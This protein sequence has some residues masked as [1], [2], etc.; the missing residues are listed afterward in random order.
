MTTWSQGMNLNAVKHNSQSINDNLHRTESCKEK[1]CTHPSL[2]GARIAERRGT[3]SEDA[4][5][6]RAARLEE[7]DQQDE[8]PIHTPR[9]RGKVRRTRWRLWPPRF[10]TTKQRRRPI[11]V[12]LP[13]PS[14][15]EAPPPFRTR[16]VAEL[17]TFY[18]S[19]S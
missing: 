13:G 9:F 5:A 4:R 1:R 19:K 7:K 6:L 8:A 14:R 18:I 15:G 2:H 3:R 16:F 10:L 17:F 11:R 12:V